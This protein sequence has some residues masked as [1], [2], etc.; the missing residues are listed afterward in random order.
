MQLPFIR[1]LALPAGYGIPFPLHPQTPFALLLLL[2]SKLSEK[3]TCTSLC[4]K[5]LDLL[6]DAFFPLSLAELLG[7]VLERLC[8]P[9]LLGLLGSIA[10]LLLPR[11]L[12]NLLVSIGIQ[13]LKAVSLDV[14]INV[15][16]EL[17]LV[18][19]LIIIGKSLHVLSNVTAED[20]LAESLGIELLGLNVEA[21]EAVLRVGD[22]ETTIRSTLHGTED[23]GTSRGTGKTNIKEHLEWAALLAINFSSLGQGEFAVS[24]LNTLESLVKLELLQRTAGKQETSS[25]SSSPVGK[26]VLSML[27]FHIQIARQYTYSDSVGLQLV[28]VSSHEDFVT[29]DL[30]ADDLSDDVTVGEADDQTVLGRIVLVL[31]LGGQALAGIVV[32]LALSAALVL[33]LVAPKVALGDKSNIVQRWKMTYEKYASFLTSLDYARVSN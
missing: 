30:S 7:P 1:R 14:V 33:D 29:A 27:A 24:L 6:L 25:V 18:T 8:L 17:R 28:S 21:R 20:V 12:A 2:S 22:I 9:L 5:L 11:V 26:T 15:A 31:G 23:T 13:L 3:R 16:A 19:L 4:L 32:G 10:L